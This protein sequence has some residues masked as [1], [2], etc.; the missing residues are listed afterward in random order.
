[1]LVAGEKQG[2]LPTEARSAISSMAS[3]F[4]GRPGAVIL[5][6]ESGQVRM[7]NAAAESMFGYRHGE[8]VGRLVEVLVPDRYRGR[9]PGQRARFVASGKLRPMGTDIELLAVRQDGVEF[10]VDISLGPLEIAE[11][12]FTLATILNRPTSRPIVPGRAPR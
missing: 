1:V 8:L 10:P 3:V 11:G 12:T 2:E 5:V 4:D 7:A 9:H 6:D